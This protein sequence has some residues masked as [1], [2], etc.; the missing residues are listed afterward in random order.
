MRTLV[1]KR[2]HD[3]DPDAKGWFG[4]HDCMGRVRDCTFDAVIGIGGIGHEARANG[5]HGKINWAGTGAQKHSLGNARGPLV[6]F[7]HFILFEGTGLD[8]WAVAPTLA[9]RMYARRAPRYVVYDDSSKDGQ[10]EIRRILALAKNAPPS[11][12]ARLPKA[13]QCGPRDGDC[14]C[15]T[16][17]N[18]VR[19]LHPSTSCLPRLLDLQFG[20]YAVLANKDNR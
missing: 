15:R 16:P 7:D 12:R 3:G 13:V 10:A 9:Q 1:Y 6:T 19:S 20:N 2:T 17:R 4:I 18:R 5:I 11:K 14:A 8:L